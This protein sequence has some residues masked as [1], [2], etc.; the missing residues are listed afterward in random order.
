[1]LEIRKEN[2]AIKDK[3]IKIPMIKNNIMNLKKALTKVIPFITIYQ[4]IN[5]K[6]VL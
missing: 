4:T 5:S 1:M 2:I 6:H 3:K